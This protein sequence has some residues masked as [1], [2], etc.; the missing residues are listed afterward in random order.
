LRFA[1]VNNTGSDPTTTI[2]VVSQ[3]PS[4]NVMIAVMAVN[5]VLT[6]AKII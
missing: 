1:T 6:G 5:R 2:P 3:A 4:A